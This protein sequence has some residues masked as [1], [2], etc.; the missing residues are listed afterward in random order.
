MAWTVFFGVY[1]VPEDLALD[2]RDVVRR[3]VLVRA[4]GPAP[5]LL[6]GA[7]ALAV[8]WRTVTSTADPRPSGS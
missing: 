2:A 5:N 6:L 3:E 8:A 4:A 1:A 7:A